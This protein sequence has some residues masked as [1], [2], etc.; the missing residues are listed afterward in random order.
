MERDGALRFPFTI[1]LDLLGGRVEQSRAMTGTAEARVRMPAA[2]TATVQM[3]T[4]HR[5]ME[6][7]PSSWNDQQRTVEVIWSTGARVLRATWG[8]DSVE[9]WDEELS[10]DPQH[11]RM[12]RLE[13]GAAVL[14]NHRQ[15]GGV[16]SVLGVVERAWLAKGEGRAVLR[17]SGR[18]ELAGFR[19]DVA[20]G[21][22]RKIS[23][24]YRVMEYDEIEE[25]KV[26]E[27]NG[28]RT[29]RAVDWEPF[30]I[31]FVTV[32]ADDAAQVRGAQ[33][34]ETH[35]CLVRCA[36]PAQP[37]PSGEQTM[38]RT[39]T[40]GAQPATP[41]PAVP[42][43][44]AIP[45]GAQRAAEPAPAPAVST[46]AIADQ[47]RAAERQ[48]TELVRSLCAKHGLERGV[49]DELLKSNLGEDAIRTS[50]LE[51]LAE[52]SA[53]TP[54]AGQLRVTVDEREKVRAVVSNSILHRA[55]PAQHKLM[56]GAGDFRGLSLRE[57]M[58]DVLEREGV[59]TRGMSLNELTTR[60]FHSTSDFPLIL[61]DVANKSMLQGYAAAPRT[62]LPFCRQANAPDFKDVHRIQL[63]EFPKLEK[64]GQ[65]GEF[66]SGT[67]SEK[68][69]KYRLATY[70][71]IVSI[72]RQV[73]INDDLAALTRIPQTYGWAAADLES[74]TVWGIITANAAM[75]DAVALFH[76]NHGNLQTGAGSALALAGLSAA[77]AAMMKQKAL[78]GKKFIMVTPKY[79][80]VPA[81]L[82]T[83]AE[84]LTTQITAA[85]SGDVNPFQ[86]KLMPIGEPRLDAASA[87][88]WYLAADPGQ[89]DTIEYAYLDGE[90][91]PRVEQRLGF[92]VDGLEIKIA[93]DF[94]AAA[95]EHRGLNKSAGA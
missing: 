42:A 74:D 37:A 55:F 18:D 62:F 85:A 92:E 81:A 73:I 40:P 30:E 28:R 2:G 79:L 33:A 41:T 70:G 93:M 51:K 86:G 47:A 84:Q 11:V 44:P 68:E 4:F 34:P 65:S 6:L 27:R 25:E 64:V 78:D 17:L 57:L 71:K 53:A 7:V 95:V 83:T 67:I 87:I 50:V 16:G 46:D 61:A 60:G 54:I 72:N 38:T 12:G 75:S 1:A 29:Y 3:P 58:R 5:E 89:V 35:S 82:L 36:A 80:L 26:K 59:R 66:K 63:G 49:E 9:Y 22:V 8:W 14:D 21:I 94:G 10:L 31:S 24:G 23:V 20:E 56:E 32:P 91:G 13:N 77:R 45:D 90:A 39:A 76:A 52:R 15:W 69:E 88:V 43:Q 19:R 48:R